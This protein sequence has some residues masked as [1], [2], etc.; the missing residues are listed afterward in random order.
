MTTALTAMF[1]PVYIQKRVYMEMHFGETAKFALT[2]IY[3]EEKN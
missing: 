2:E 1:I 3:E